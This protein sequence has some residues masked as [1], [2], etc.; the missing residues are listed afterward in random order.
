MKLLI[1]G[2]FSYTEKQIESLQNLGFEISFIERE[3]G[4]LDVDVSQI[5]CVVCNWLMVHHD[6]SQFKSLK[7]IQLLSAG[8]ERVPVDYIKGKD[9]ALYN[10]RGVY[11]IPMA[12]FAIC[13]VLQLYKDSREIALQQK[14]RIWAKRRD[15]LELHDKRVLILGV[16]SV[17]TEVAKRFAAFTDKVYGVDLFP[18]GTEGFREVYPISYLDEELFESDVVVITLPLT[19]E[20]ENLIDKKRLSNM[21]KGAVLINIARGGIVDED[22]LVEALNGHLK[23]AAV[24][25]FAEEPLP[26]ESKLWEC[27]NLIISPH[28]SFV[29]DGN[30]NRMWNCIYSNLKNFLK[31]FS[32]ASKP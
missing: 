7:C 21:K 8:L 31:N 17:G 23:G 6:V 15:L 2:A 13:S 20:T 9:I 4:V 16:G 30:D 3:D 26:M 32:S 27:E 1:T 10:A 24:D 11:S 12:E 5:D 25:V 14:K 22:G 29:S 18:K 19:D 28:N